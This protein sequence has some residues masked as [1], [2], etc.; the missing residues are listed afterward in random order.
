MPDQSNQFTLSLTEAEK[1][2]LLR[3]L[4]DFFDET[5]LESRRTDNP[6]YRHE[7]HKEEDVLKSLLAKVRQLGN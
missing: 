7:L 1:T 4:G 3:V 2:E 5:H 6:T